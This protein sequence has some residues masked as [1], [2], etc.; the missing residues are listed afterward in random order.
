M[1]QVW[2]CGGGTQSC[3]IAVL[4]IQGKLPK[5]DVSVIADTGRE[6]GTTWDYMDKVLVPE[7]A[8][9]GVTLHRVKASEWASTSDIFNPS[10]TMLMPCFSTL[11]GNGKL[12]AFCSS[13]WKRDALDKWLRVNM[14]LKEA[15]RVKWI[16]FSLDEANRVIR[17]RR[18]V[19]YVLGQ[20]RFP[21]VEDFPMRRRDAIRLVESMGWPTPPRSACWMCPNQGDAEWRDLKLN[22]PEEFAAAVALEKDIRARDPHA[23]LHGSCVPLDQV[24]FTEPADLFKA[25]P[26]ESGGCFT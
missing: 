20:I 8:K 21:L 26:C 1:K 7:L 18:S 25:Q 17:M 12:P 6:K 9:V 24:D 15:E 14:G 4:I 22:H 2:S 19:A 3:A 10:G 13:Y 5:P 23:F 11:N 16:G